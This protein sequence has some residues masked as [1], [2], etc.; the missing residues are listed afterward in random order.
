MNAGSDKNVEDVE[1]RRDKI[2]LLTNLYIALF[3]SITIL[4]CCAKKKKVPRVEHKVPIPTGLTN[5]ERS[6]DVHKSSSPANSPASASP[7]PTERTRRKSKRNTE[8]LQTPGKAEKRKKAKKRS[9]ETVK[10]EESTK[11]RRKISLEKHEEEELEVMSTQA[12]NPSSSDPDSVGTARIEIIQMKIS[13]SPAQ[14]QVKRPS[15]ETLTEKKPSREAIAEKKPSRDVL[16]E[17]KPSRDVLAE[18]KPSRELMATAR[19]PS[20]E[21]LTENPPVMKRSRECENLKKSSSSSHDKEE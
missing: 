16:A 14:K 12:S 10:K 15:K 1:K 4:Q 20:K 6:S 3:V 17:K 8:K 5:S 13:Q 7:S 18:R 9:T 21:A 11:S 19:K 2:V